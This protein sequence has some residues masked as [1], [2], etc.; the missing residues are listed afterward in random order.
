VSDPAPL[1]DVRDLS[2]VFRTPEG[3]VAAVQDVSFVLRPGE[4]LAV[5]GESG[6]GKSV[7][8]L[9]IMGL[10]PQPH[11]RI[12]RGSIAF[13]GRDGTV[14]DLARLPPA[15][16]RRIRGN[17]IAMI[18]QEPMTSLNPLFTVGEQIMEPLRLHQRMSRAAA[19][20]RAADL[21]AL[22]GIPDPRRRL[23]VHPHEMSGGMRQRVMIAM[24]LAC[25]PA[26][27]IAD[28]PT[29]ALD[30]TIQAQILDLLR[31]IQQRLRMGVI[32]ITHDL[33][34]VAQIADRVLVMYAGRVVETADRMAAL[35]RPRHPYLAGLLGSIPRL[36]PAD[37][38]R[39]PLK[40]IPGTPANPMRPPPG[41][42][43]HPRCAF[44]QAGR[45]DVEAPAL[46][47]SGPETTVRCHRWRELDLEIAA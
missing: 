5:V 30:V 44:A 40:P 10:V 16:H 6:S 2:V 33:G 25:D 1:L 18:F 47:A 42:A 22:V 41:C 29:T 3:P 46:V 8:S 14:R 31:E 37:G 38:R 9:A 34:T 23:D 36:D 17:Q 32:F 12:A 24:A 39:L 13:R 35:T 15:E 27:L 45:C 19:R 28:E 21:M 7:S 20:D 11:G 26:L 4:T 43:F